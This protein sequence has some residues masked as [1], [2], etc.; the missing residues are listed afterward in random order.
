M[1]NKARHDS[2]KQAARC[3][4]L[5]PTRDLAHQLH[6]EVCKL[7]KG[8][9]LKCVVLDKANA[10]GAAQA[11]TEALKKLHVEKDSGAP[12][13][14]LADIVIATPLLLVKLIQDCPQQLQCVELVILDEMDKLFELGF[15]EQV[16]R[17]RCSHWHSS[18]NWFVRLIQYLLLA[19]TKTSSEPCL[20]QPC[21][22]EQKI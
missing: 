14:P 13:V 21:Q 22:K 7:C 5:S 2:Q 16:C 1:S 19:H 17:C 3:I 8:T 12:A 6:R 10:A 20:R 11:Q 18:L 9:G 4:I 15:L